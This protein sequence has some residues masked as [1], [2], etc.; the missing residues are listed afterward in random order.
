MV[1]LMSFWSSQNMPPQGLL[2]IA[3]DLQ[4][5]L[6]AQL[7]LTCCKTGQYSSTNQSLP[8]GSSG[9]EQNGGI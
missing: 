1:L 9:Q 4:G 2:N 8:W 7:V 3:Q 6:Q 5:S